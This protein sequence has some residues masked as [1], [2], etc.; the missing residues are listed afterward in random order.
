MTA[1]R[2]T[3]VRSNYSLSYTLNISK[4]DKSSPLIFRGR[5]KSDNVRVLLYSPA[6]YG[7]ALGYV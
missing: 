6:F 7:L 1:S 4:N 3:E 2:C 5:P